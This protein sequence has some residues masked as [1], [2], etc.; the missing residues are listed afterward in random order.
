MFLCKKY[1]RK[2]AGLPTAVAKTML[3]SSAGSEGLQK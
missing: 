2:L 1:F 3:M